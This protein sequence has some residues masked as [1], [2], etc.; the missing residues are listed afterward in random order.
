MVK[1]L[2]EIGGLRGGPRALQGPHGDTPT[3]Q[4]KKRILS[5]SDINRSRVHRSQILV[6]SWSGSHV[7]PLSTGLQQPHPTFIKLQYSSSSLQ[8]AMGNGGLK[9]WTWNK[10]GLEST[11]NQWG[12]EDMVGPICFLSAFWW[13]FYYYLPSN[14]PKRENGIFPMVYFRQHSPT[15]L[16]DNHFWQHVLSL[17]HTNKQCW[18]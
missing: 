15:K 4:Q 7:R 12:I 14:T 9:S 11:E 5:F 6:L 10:Y 8:K 18:S 3:K 1:V 2:F 13:V 16:S 17:V